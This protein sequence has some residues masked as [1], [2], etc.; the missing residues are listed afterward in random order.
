MR[1]ALHSGV[2]LVLSCWAAAVAPDATAVS[3]DVSVAASADDAE[4][5]ASGS[6]TLNS[7]DL[8]L[9]FDKSNQ[10][11][12]LRFA[13]VGVPRGASIVTAYVQFEVD[14]VSTAAASL[15]VQGQAADNPGTFTSPTGNVSARP[16]TSAS[17]AWS[18]PAWPTT[19]VAGPDQR[20]PDLSAVVQEI[21][22]RP[23]WATANALVILVTGAGRRT[24]EAFDGTAAPIL[25]IEY[26]VN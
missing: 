2:W 7:S 11:V 14:E 18:P 10:T 23:G 25:H 22:N 12:G 17:V 13:G 24:A 16:R 3:L 6:V 8:E 26:R 19:P 5:S 20:T 21:V 9:V 15:A 1:R 4:E